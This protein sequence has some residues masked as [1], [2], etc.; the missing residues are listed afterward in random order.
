[1]EESAGARMDLDYKESLRELKRT[2]P[3]TDYESNRPEHKADGK[4]PKSIW[5]SKT[6]KV[7]VFEDGCP[8]LGWVRPHHAAVLSQ[9]QAAQ[10]CLRWY[11]RS[12][13]Y[14]P[15]K[16]VLGEHILSVG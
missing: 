4:D 5:K 3:H 10:T 13:E 12:P 14:H 8:T 6:G 7:M 2:Y 1:M 16:K 11:L 9:D 15:L